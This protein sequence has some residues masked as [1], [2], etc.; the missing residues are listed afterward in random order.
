[1]NTVV[2]NLE[3]E[4]YLAEKQRN[5]NPKPTIGFVPTMGALHAGH[6]ALIKQAKKH[7]DIVVCSIFVNPTQ[8]NDP[9]DLEKYPRTPEK[10][11][12]MLEEASCDILFMPSVEEIYPEKKE[13]K[14]DL[15]Y[16]A[17]ILEG[18]SRLGHFNGV[19]QVVHR[20]FEIVKPNKAFFGLKDYQQVVIVKQVAQQMAFPLEIIPCAI[21]REDSGLAM[22]SRNM[23]LSEEEKEIAANISRIL[24]YAKSTQ[25]NYRTYEDLRSVCILAFN[26]VQGIKLDYLEIRHKDTFQSMSGKIQEGAIMLCAAYVGPVRL[27]DNLIL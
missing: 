19:A 22:S 21:V 15:G 9:K 16:V 14:I 13:F 20:L 27:I 8:F 11:S 26:E 6:I 23:R 12:K 3:L 4:H 18:A 25:N 5:V 24:F 2:T 1:M 7:C 17:T 10:D